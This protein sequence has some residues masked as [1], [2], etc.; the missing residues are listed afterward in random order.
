M[1]LSYLQCRLVLLGPALPR[2]NIQI[3]CQSHGMLHLPTENFVIV[4][5]LD[6]AGDAWREE[7][8]MQQRAHEPAQQ[9]ER[10]SMWTGV[11]P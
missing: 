6:V 11:N 4:A 3:P 9:H 8:G 5:Y 10:E 1:P 7:D 2:R